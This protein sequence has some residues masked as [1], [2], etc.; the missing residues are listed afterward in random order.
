MLLEK[1]LQVAESEGIQE[2]QI[3]NK[4]QERYAAFVR[5]GRLDN[6]RILQ[7]ATGIEPSEDVVQEGYAAFVREGRLDDLKVLKEAT[8]IEP[9]LSEDVVQE[10]YAAF[11]R[12][13]RLGNLQVLKEATGIEPSED[14]YKI[15]IS[16][17]MK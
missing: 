7:E 10:R 6:L 1:L 11:V 2:K 15:L 13:G 17:I 8:G 4:I 12:K 9:S 16:Q 5:E 3:R 14:V